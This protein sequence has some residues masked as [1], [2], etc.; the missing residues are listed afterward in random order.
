MLNRGI[1]GEMAE[2][3]TEDGELFRKL[4]QGGENQTTSILYGGGLPIANCQLS[5]RREYLGRPHI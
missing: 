4:I 5:I 2:G 3:I 1:K